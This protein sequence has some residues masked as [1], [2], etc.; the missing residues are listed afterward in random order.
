MK[1]AA[2]CGLEQTADYPLG[3]DCIS[4]SPS[5][6]CA[7]RVRRSARYP[8]SGL[9]VDDRPPRPLTFSQSGKQLQSANFE[10]MVQPCTAC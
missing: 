4:A 8:L 1:D 7:I 6:I 9:F 3:V 5:A 10:Q 2:S